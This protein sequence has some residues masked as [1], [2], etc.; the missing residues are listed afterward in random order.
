MQ[1]WKYLFNE[2]ILDRGYF[3]TDN[4]KIT[5]FDKNIVTAKVQ[6]TFDYDTRITFKDGL[7]D[8]MFCSCP[9]FE[10]DNCKHLAAL[11]YVIEDD[12][13]EYLADD[14]EDFS[15]LFDSVS[16]DDLKDF[17]YDELEENPELLNKF[18]LKFSDSV[19]PKYYKSKLFNI[20][21]ENDRYLI[22]DFLSEDM[23]FLLK[24]GEYELVFNLSKD[25]F[26]EIKKWWNYWEDFG[27]DGNIEE[28]EDIL[29][30]LIKSKI[31]D[32][33]F[34]WL[35]ELI[36]SIPDDYHMEGLTDLY[37][38]EF[39][40]RDELERKEK[41]VDRII[42]KTGSARWI[43]IKLDLMGKL[44]YCDDEINDLWEKYLCNEEIMQQYINSSEGSKKEELLKKA[45]NQFEYNET[46]RFQLKN[47]YLENDW[48][49][50][51]EELEK[52][53]FS[54]PR[55]E[56]FK[57]FKE[58]YS[59]NWTEKR[60]ELFDMH[61]NLN[62]LYALEGLN[63]RLIENIHSLWE[64]DR[65][66][67]VLAV[68]HSERLIEMYTD[69]AV[70][71]AKSSGTPKHYREIADVLKTIHDLPG[72]EEVSENLVCEFKEKYKR[73]PRMMSQLRYIGF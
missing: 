19:D 18:K 41:L 32:E 25:I 54:Y 16:D 28:L 62:E 14:N 33:V 23:D 72:G 4:V 46:Y 11:L 26:P 63:D 65:Y 51:M 27:S 43:L 48:D 69:I 9:Y 40:S 53:V 59:G 60:E 36:Y 56:Y 35:G 44:D 6:G 13:D 24:K 52:L 68:T 47:Y 45:I 50:Y 30:E 17:L 42:E 10:T 38:T 61:S 37:F 12:A 20:H 1:N 8:G 22:N 21:F 5:R 49:R 3:Y 31:H 64:L 67:D 29:A 70:S 2:K 58:N 39:N 71:M 73:R 7:I 15:Q 55:V 57:E 66:K 34:E